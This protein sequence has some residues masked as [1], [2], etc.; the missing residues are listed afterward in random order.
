[1]FSI[2]CSWQLGR[3]IALPRVCKGAQELVFSAGCNRERGGLFKDLISE[4]SVPH[5]GT[6]V[7]DDRKE[8]TISINADKS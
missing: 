6:G 7:D 8:E 2:V 4:F 5:A 1:M 3:Q